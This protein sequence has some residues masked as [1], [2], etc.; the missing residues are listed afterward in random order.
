MPISEIELNMLKERNL[1][2]SRKIFGFG[3]GSDIFE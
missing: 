1:K 2:I 3:F